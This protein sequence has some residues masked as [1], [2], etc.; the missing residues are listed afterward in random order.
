MKALCLL[1]KVSRPVGVATSKASL[2]AVLSDAAAAAVMG[3][4]GG[5]RRCNELTAQN[6]ANHVDPHSAWM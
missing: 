5:C 3:A 1:P 6:S 4:L 2:W